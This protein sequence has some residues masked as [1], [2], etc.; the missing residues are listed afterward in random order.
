MR[1]ACATDP[2]A[3]TRRRPWPELLDLD[4]RRDGVAVVTLANGKVNALSAAL[5]AELQAAA[6][7]VDRRSPRAPSSS[8][9]ATGSSPPAPTSPSSGRRRGRSD[10]RRLPRRARRRR[11]HPALRD[12]RGQ[13]LRP[14]GRLRARARLR[15]PIAG[16]RAVFG[17]PR[18][19]RR[20]PGRWR[21]A[22]AGPPRR[23][24]PGQG[25]VHHRPPGARPTRRWASASPTRSSTSVLLAGR[26]SSP[27]SPAGPR[28]SQSWSSGRHRRRTLST[29][30]DQRP[31]P[32]EQGEIVE[33]WSS[34]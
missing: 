23:P 32:L 25:A 5:L 21:H 3:L 11:R 27:P 15:R 29:S 22:A 34:T 28:Q 14:G 17:H 7:D 16:P 31:A 33:V 19:A 18:S 2:A 1:A 9:A 24:E 26:S 30:L 13:R 4:R 12:R 10:H 20:H 6:G 8:P